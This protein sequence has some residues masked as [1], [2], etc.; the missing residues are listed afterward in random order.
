MCLKNLDVTDLLGDLFT[1]ILIRFG[2]GSF[3]LD[4][5]L[6]W[7]LKDSSNGNGGSGRS[8]PG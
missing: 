3:L 1:E 7:F 2:E 4:S 5:F 6:A 8:L